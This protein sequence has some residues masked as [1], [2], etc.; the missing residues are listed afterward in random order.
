MIKHATASTFVF[1]QFPDRWRLGLVAQPRLGRHMIVGG[2]VEDDETQA[3]AALRET[4]EESGLRVRLL[5]CP[6]P[7]LPSGYPHERVASP[8]WITEV[9][10]PEDNHLAEPHVHVDHQYV[11]I[12]DSPTPVS[13][14]VHPFAW[15]SEDELGGLKMFDDTRLLARALFPIMGSIA[16]A[17]GD[18]M[19]LLRVLADSGLD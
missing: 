11:A 12:A 14:P 8:W 1:H 7:A 15:F 3:E 16:A 9:M 17:D 13:E 2:H 4:E 19:G 18:E 10:V 6:T 5:A